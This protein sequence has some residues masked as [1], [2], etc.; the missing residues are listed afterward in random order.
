MRIWHH[1]HERQIQIM[2]KGFK[3]LKWQAFWAEHTLDEWMIYKDAIKKL[4]LKLYL[5]LSKDVIVAYDELCQ[6]IVKM[7]NEMENFENECFQKSHTCKDV[8]QGLK[9]MN[10][11]EMLVADGRDGN[12]KLHVAVMG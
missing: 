12:W 6:I 8:L 11:V 4:R 2:K 1:K 7:K 9:L 5:K 3:T 10:L